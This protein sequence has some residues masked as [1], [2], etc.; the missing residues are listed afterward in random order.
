VTFS[1]P[2]AVGIFADVLGYEFSENSYPKT[3]QTNC[4]AFS[5]N[6]SHLHG[7][8]REASLAGFT[9]KKNILKQPPHNCGYCLLFHPK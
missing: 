3:C 2:Q 4:Y 8:I 1:P 5:P 9:K 7:F 6:F